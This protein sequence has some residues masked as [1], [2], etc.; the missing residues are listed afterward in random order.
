MAVLSQGL[1]CLLIANKVIAEQLLY[2]PPVF[3][4]PVGPMKAYWR[5]KGDLLVYGLMMP[6]QVRGGNVGNVGN[7]GCPLE[8]VDEL[9][10]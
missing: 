1:C 5:M 3:M 9:V 2:L 10:S 6:F 7:V 8:I 4:P